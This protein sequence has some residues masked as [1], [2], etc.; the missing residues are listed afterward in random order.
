MILFRYQKFQTSEQSNLVNIFCQAG[1]LLS[2]LPSMKYVSQ[3]KE[4]FS[5]SFSLA[6][7]LPWMLALVWLKKDFISFIMLFV[8]W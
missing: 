2:T 3:L 1:T 7:E 4:F 6:D 5:F 8:F